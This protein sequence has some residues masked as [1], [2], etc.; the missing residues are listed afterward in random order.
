M[1]ARWIDDTVG[2]FHQHATQLRLQPPGEAVAAAQTGADGVR[3]RVG[4]QGEHSADHRDVRVQGLLL[5]GESGLGPVSR[6]RHGGATRGGRENGLPRRRRQH[7]CVGA[8]GRF[9]SCGEEDALQME[10]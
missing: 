7:C 6:R 10:R 4:G 3:V 2:S 1:C 9:S 5:R 8:S